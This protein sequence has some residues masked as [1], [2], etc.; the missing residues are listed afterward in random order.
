ML[1]Q[2]QTAC[3]NLQARISKVR[4]RTTR[5]SKQTPALLAPA[6]ASEGPVTDIAITVLATVTVLRALS[7]REPNPQAADTLRR[8]AVTMPPLADRLAHAW[9]RARGPFVAFPEEALELPFVPARILLS[10]VRFHID[11]TRRQAPPIDDLQQAIDAIVQLIDETRTALP[12]I[13]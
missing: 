9:T 10:L 3:G 1:D 6:T 8:Y 13:A 7:W 4:A 11:E 12:P 2:I 5:L